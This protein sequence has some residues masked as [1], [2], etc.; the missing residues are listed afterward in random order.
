M[1]LS[2]QFNSYDECS[3]DYTEQKKRDFDALTLV[4]GL[5]D[6]RFQIDSSLGAFQERDQVYAL[7]Y[8]GLF[9]KL[10]IIFTVEKI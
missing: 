4:L 6:R 1:T 7:T 5:C 9:G 8:L 10:F 3:N 2:D